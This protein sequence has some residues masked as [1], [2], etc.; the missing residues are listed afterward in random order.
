M[1]LQLLS[2]TPAQIANSALLVLTCA[3]AC[4][5]EDTHNAR[6]ATTIDAGDT[7]APNTDTSPDVTQKA[8]AH[9]CDSATIVELAAIGEAVTV[10]LHFTNANG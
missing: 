8:D 6:S 7:D 4:S 3:F 9:S 2:T 5:S 10:T 1:G